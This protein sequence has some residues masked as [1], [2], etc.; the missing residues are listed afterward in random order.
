M[1]EKEQIIQSTPSFAQQAP[2]TGRLILGILVFAPLL[3]LALPILLLLRWWLK[4]KS[5]MRTLKE[6]EPR[7]RKEGLTWNSEVERIQFEDLSKHPAKNPIDSISDIYQMAILGATRLQLRGGEI[8][9]FRIF[10]RKE[11]GTL[12]ISL[13][14]S[15]DW[16]LWQVKV[17]DTHIDPLIYFKHLLYLFE[18][19]AFIIERNLNGPDSNGLK[20]EMKRIIESVRLC[21]PV[22]YQSTQRLKVSP[23][24]IGRQITETL[25]GPPDFLHESEFFKQSPFRGSRYERQKL[26]SPRWPDS[27]RYQTAAV[28]A[29]FDHLVMKVSRHYRIGDIQHLRI[30][31]G[32]DMLLEIGDNAGMFGFGLLSDEGFGKLPADIIKSIDSI[33]DSELIHEYNIPPDTN[34]F[35]QNMS[36]DALVNFIQ[37]VVAKHCQPTSKKRNKRRK[38]GVGDTDA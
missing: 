38:T 20:K 32:L 16:S 1:K 30:L 22:L 9:K 15:E 28:F 36:A 23:F 24:P 18:D 12:Q 21:F 34:G 14:G 25:T 19:C 10:R 11:I 5:I 4:R 6:L 2:S 13:I 7:F 27:S 33:S 17:V 3:T 37:V 31:Y 35:Y 29:A 26:K 8:E